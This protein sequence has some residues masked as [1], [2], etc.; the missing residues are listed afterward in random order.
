MKLSRT[1]SYALQAVVRLGDTF[2]QQPFPCSRLAAEGKMPDRFL[3]QILRSLVAHGI[4]TSTRGIFGGYT[5][6]R[7]PKKITL[8]EIVEAIDGSLTWALPM[9]EAFPKRTRGKLQDLLSQVHD[10]VRAEL[11]SVTVADLLARS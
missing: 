4:L 8:L 3:I 9:V 5:L 7:P 6:A 11:A 2:G 1:V 10:A